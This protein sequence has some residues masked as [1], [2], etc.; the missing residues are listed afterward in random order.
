M[1]QQLELPLTSVPKV[2]IW[3]VLTF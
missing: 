3:G 1:L 2:T